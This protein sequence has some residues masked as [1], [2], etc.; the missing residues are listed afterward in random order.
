MPITSYTVVGLFDDFATAQ[1][2]RKELLSSGFTPDDV[3]LS[4]GDDFSDFSIG[5][6]R[7]NTGLMGEPRSDA[8]GG[9]IGGFFRRLFDTDVD[10]IESRRFSEAMRQGAAV[11]SVRA[12]EANEDR[13]ADIMNQYG[14]IDI[15]QHAASGSEGG[16]TERESVREPGECSVPVV[17]EELNVGKRAVQRGGVRVFSRVMEE[18][19]EER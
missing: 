7:G 8:V 5:A 3:H 16:Y 19:V 10:E 9:G 4:S 6:A 2:V 14:A 12:S 17:R 11:V 13:A 15:D 1:S 18:P